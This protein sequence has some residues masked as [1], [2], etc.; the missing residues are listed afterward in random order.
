MVLTQGKLPT[1]VN[2]SPDP[3]YAEV[4]LYYVRDGKLRNSD[5]VLGRRMCS[6]RPC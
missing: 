1:L 6:D 5:V 3:L 4:L 2:H